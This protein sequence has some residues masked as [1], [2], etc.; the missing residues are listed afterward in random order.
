[1][2]RSPGTL[3]VALIF[4]CVLVLGVAYNAI[5]GDGKDK[6][7]AAKAK[8]MPVFVDFGRTTCNPCKMM[9]PVLG[10]L[11]RK[12]KGKME[13]VFVHVDEEKGYALKMGVTMIPTQV[14]LDKEGRE[15]ARHVGYMPVEDCDKMIGKVVSR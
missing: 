8:G 1:M 4:T 9:V 13:V 3:A 10:S 15:V 14:L 12:Y 11:T 7:E 5:A 2:T 6:V